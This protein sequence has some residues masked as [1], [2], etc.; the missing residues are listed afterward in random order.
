MKKC[1][2][3]FHK[4]VSTLTNMRYYLFRTVDRLF[5]K[6]KFSIIHDTFQ[7]MFDFI[8]VIF[9][10]AQ[11]LTIAISLLFCTTELRTQHAHRISCCTIVK[12]NAVKTASIRT[13]I[14]IDMMSEI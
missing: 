7:L 8:N 12:Y 4:C 10:N 14:E 3:S 5:R 1:L 11:R 13:H 9:V 2:N 6:F